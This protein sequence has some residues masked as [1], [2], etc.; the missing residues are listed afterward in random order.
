MPRPPLSD[1]ASAKIR[2][3]RLLER[4]KRAREA[5][6]LEGPKKIEQECISDD[7]GDDDGD[8]PLTSDDWELALGV[9]RPLRREVVRWILEV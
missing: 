3:G 2:L 8:M 4:E 9:G 5:D 6:G 7:C 1:E